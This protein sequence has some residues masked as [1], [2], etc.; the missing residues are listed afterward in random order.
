MTTS[1]PRWDDVQLMQWAD[2]VLPPDAAAALEAAFLH[3]ADL[4]DR[5]ARMQQ[6]REFVREAFATQLAPVPPALRKSVEQMAA[7]HTQPAATPSPAPTPPL[8]TAPSPRP[9]APRAQQPWWQRWGIAWPVGAFPGALAASVVAGIVGVWVGQ[10]TVEPRDGGSTMQTATVGSTAPAELALLL[11]RTPS[12]QQARLGTQGPQLA[13][14]G[15]FTDGQG[16]LCRDFSLQSASATVES[17]ACRMPGDDWQIVFSALQ[18][19]AQSGF[20]LA[21][22]QSAVDSFLAGMGAKG[23]LSAPA[24]REALGLR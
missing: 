21:G 23:P 20:S 11:S 15:S 7:R 12:G 17:I 9:A 10:S 4:A 16:R 3:D 6:T 24:E 22:P 2:G 5:A 13:M 8:D 18:P 1:P 14:V 19:T